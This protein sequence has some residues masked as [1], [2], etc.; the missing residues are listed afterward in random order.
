MLVS[1]PIFDVL[2]KLAGW[3]LVGE[4]PRDL[5]KALVIVCPHATWKDFPIGVGARSLLKI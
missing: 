2:F 5:K 1:S 4:V 3:K